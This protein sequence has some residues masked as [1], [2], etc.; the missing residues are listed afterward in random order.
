MDI[1]TKWAEPVEQSEST[2][3]ETT[4][5]ESESLLT[6]PISTKNPVS[7][8]TLKPVKKNFKVKFADEASSSDSE[9]LSL[10]VEFPCETDSVSSSSSQVG[11][12]KH[13]QFKKKSFE[14][15]RKLLDKDGTDLDL[16]EVLKGESDET[17]DADEQEG[18][19]PG[20]LAEA[21]KGEEGG[22]DGSKPP[23]RTNGDEL[24][25]MATALLETWSSLKV[26]L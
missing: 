20:D 13:V 9:S 11:T 2:A 21:E 15:R 22:A 12:S 18:V 23:P 7:I 3:A 14:L 25:N 4:E 8:L 1:V 24:T 10:E 16:K 19:A 17:E 26:K 6:P 5:D